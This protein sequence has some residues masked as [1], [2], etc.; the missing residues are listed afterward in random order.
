MREI[1]AGE[2]YGSRAR[3][4]DHAHAVWIRDEDR[5]VGTPHE[6][7]CVLVGGDVE[8]ELRCVC[9]ICAAEPLHRWKR[10]DEVVHEGQVGDLSW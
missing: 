9:A 5:L 7:E 6:H 2:R 4:V 8:K 1:V 10:L 3:T